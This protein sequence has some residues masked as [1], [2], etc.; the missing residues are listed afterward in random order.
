M[1][2]KTDGSE[3]RPGE[4]RDARPQG[5]VRGGAIRGL[6]RGRSEACPEAAS[7]VAPYV[8]ERLPKEVFR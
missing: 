7:S 4:A 5:S 1:G 8:R 3:P 6:P 2:K